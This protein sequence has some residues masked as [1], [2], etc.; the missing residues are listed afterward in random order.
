MPEALALLALAVAIFARA[1]LPF[2]G[3]TKSKEFLSPWR[4][5]PLSKSPHWARGMDTIKSHRRLPHV[6]C[7]L[8]SVVLW[9]L[10]L[11]SLTANEGVE[12]TYRLPA[13]DSAFLDDLQRRAVRYFVEQTDPATGLTL[14]RS[15]VDG[16]IGDSPSSVAATGFALTAWCIADARGW[17]H[18]GDALKRVRHTLRFLVQHHAH[19]HGFFYHFVDGSTGKRAWN[20]EAST[21]DTALLLQGALFAREYLRD[22]EVTALV[23]WIY[24]RIDWQWAMNDGR[25]LSHG[26]MPEIGFIEHRWERY[27]ELLGLYLLGIGAPRKPLPAEAWNAW[28]REPRVSFG[29]RTFIQCGPLFTHQYAHGWFDF[30][31]RRDTHADY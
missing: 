16:G 10:T 9:L 13:R 28:S 1:P 15:S 23:E 8:R 18:P 29:E 3:I 2:T 31:G 7:A 25:T 30:R 4:F 21:I 19:E 6:S 11:G 20:S 14:D 12:S 24:A 5:V 26:W 17:V 22:R 27:A